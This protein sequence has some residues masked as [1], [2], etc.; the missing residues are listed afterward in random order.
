MAGVVEG[1]LRTY[2]AFV[3][4]PWERGLAGPQKVWFA[5]YDPPQERRLRL[6]IEEFA[7]ATRDAGHHWVHH[8]LTTIFEEW[9]ATHRHR[10]AYFAEPEFFTY[11]L[12]AFASH[13][14]EFVS[15]TLT[16]E[17][18]DENTVVAISGVGALFGLTS[19]SQLA[20]RVAPAI[21]GRL[22]VFFPGDYHGTS[23]R[24]LDAKDGWN[25]LA[26]PI[27]AANGGQA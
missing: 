26:V 19:V 12:D 24:L 6:R 1:L 3:K 23:Y 22:L 8:D 7:I 18:V 27:T 9:M 5:I 21:R 20:E 11:A 14:A 25:Y 16:A 13:L 15:G 10:D 2:T 17:D 4:I